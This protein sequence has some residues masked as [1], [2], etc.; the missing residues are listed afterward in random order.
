MLSEIVST[1][2]VFAQKE[3]DNWS[4]NSYL[5]ERYKSPQAAFNTVARQYVKDMFANSKAELSKDGDAELSQLALSIRKYKALSD[6]SSK[7]A[8]LQFRKLQKR[9]PVWS[10]VEDLEFLIEFGR[11]IE[12]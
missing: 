8:L 10:N 1:A 2:K 3:S 7:A 11:N 4:K 5:Q 9:E 6:T 12:K